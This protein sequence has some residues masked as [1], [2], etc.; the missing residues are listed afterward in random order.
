MKK[1]LILISII[2]YGSN[3]VASSLITNIE[4]TN[5]ASKGKISMDITERQW[6]NEIF[7]VSLQAYSP[8]YAKM[9][10]L[11]PDFISH[12]IPD[13]MESLEIRVLTIGS[14]NVCFFNFTVNSNLNIDFPATDINRYEFRNFSKPFVQRGVS[15]YIPEIHNAKM[16]RENIDDYYGR[17][18]II[19]PLSKNGGLGEGGVHGGPIEYYSR[20]YWPG[21][22]LFS[23]RST[24]SSHILGGGQ[25]AIWLKKEVGED[26]TK[27]ADANLDDFYKFTIPEKLAKEAIPVMDRAYAHMKSNFNALKK[28]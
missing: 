14:E 10:D 7:D 11:N 1:I 4:Q 5:G 8:K 25:A 9:F 12:E 2:L 3:A 22:T 13:G 15:N 6:R 27:K 17:N 16:K 21:L 24:C 20:N 28:Q 26:Y 23:L 18:R 19:G